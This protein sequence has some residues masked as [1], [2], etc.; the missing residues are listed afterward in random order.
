MWELC[1]RF[2]AEFLVFAFFGVLES[3]L[4]NCC[5]LEVLRMIDIF[6]D[7]IGFGFRNILFLFFI[8]KFFLLFDFFF[9]IFRF[10]FGRWLM[11][12]VSFFFWWLDRF[13]WFLFRYV[14]LRGEVIGFGISVFLWWEFSFEFFDLDF[15]MWKVVTVLIGVEVRFCFFIF[16][17]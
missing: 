8:I 15:F 1:V 11:S 10:D 13:L 7:F 17:W 12:V 9:V 5:V 14:F 2:I 16:L 4:F 6:L 3:V